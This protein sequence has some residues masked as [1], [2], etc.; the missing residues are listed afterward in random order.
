MG[1][2]LMFILDGKMLRRTSCAVIHRGYMA[3]IEENVPLLDS[4]SLLDALLYDSL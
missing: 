4:K 1:V 2:A 3:E